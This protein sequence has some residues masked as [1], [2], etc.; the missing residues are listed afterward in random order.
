MIVLCQTL[1]IYIYRVMHVTA[2][3]RYKSRPVD[4]KNDYV[5][6]IILNIIQK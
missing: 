2:L 1:F 4:S 6:R 5:Q 3:I